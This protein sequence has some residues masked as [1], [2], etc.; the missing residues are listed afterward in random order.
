MKR[1]GYDQNRSYMLDRVTKLGNQSK[2][3][4][5]IE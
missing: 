1:C 2:M 5:V 3:K 4:S